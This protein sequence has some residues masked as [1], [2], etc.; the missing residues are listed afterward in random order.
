MH[1]AMVM[2]VAQ[3]A[4][5]VD[6]DPDARLERACELIVDAG[7]AGA[8]WIVFPETY[9]P[10]APAWIWSVPHGDALARDLHSIALAHA[11]VIPGAI[12]ERLCRVAQRSRVCVAIGVVERDNE[13]CYSS[14]LLI[15]AHGRICG[16]NRAALSSTSTQQS[17][18]PVASTTMMLMEQAQAQPE[19]ARG[20]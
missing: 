1:S 16:H 9:L 3:P 8:G 11:V 20:I 13:S 6:F 5:L 4:E 14:L 19:W 7:Q 18:S 17:W 12:S 10:G 15:D 2:V